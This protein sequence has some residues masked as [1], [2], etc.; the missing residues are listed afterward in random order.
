MKQATF[1]VDYLYEADEYDYHLTGR[2]RFDMTL[3]DQEYEELYKIWESHDEELNNWETDWTGQEEWFDRINDV[4]IY[5]LKKLLKE[6]EPEIF[7]VMSSMDV[8]W[9]LSQE[10]ANAF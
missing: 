5:A 3:S 4:A 1:Y 10:T 9:E 6:K 8:L 7:K 2:Y